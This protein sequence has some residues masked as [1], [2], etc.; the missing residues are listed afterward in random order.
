MVKLDDGYLRKHCSSCGWAYYPQVFDSVAAVI[1]KDKK[2]LLVK[3]GREPH[4]NTWMFPGGFIEYGEH[5]EETLKREVKEETGLKVKKISLFEIV[6]TDDDPRAPGNLIFF[7]KVEPYFSHLRTDRNENIDIDWF[8]KN[9]LPN[10]G[11]KSHKYI[12]K[13]I[14]KEK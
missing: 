3:R 2:I 12:I 9:D 6:Q 7:Y 13:L 4:K 10:I 11:W 1:S 5:P 14:S 8:S